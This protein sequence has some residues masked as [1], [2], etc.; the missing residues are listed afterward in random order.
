MK[1]ASRNRGFTLIDVLVLIVLIGTVAGSMT[2]LFSRL[3]AQ[4]AQ[5]MRARQQLGLA[6][7][8]LAE[9]RLMPM[10]AGDPMGPAGKSRY[11]GP[12]RFDNVNDYNGLML[13]DA[14]CAGGICDIGRRALIPAGSPLTGCS[15]TIATVPQALPGVPAVDALRI[16]V[17]VRCPGQ[18]DTT[19]EGIR[20]RHS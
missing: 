10:T 9:V 4:S 1:P 15:A 17:T 19:A 20:I 3:S 16:V 11:P 2:V 12:N 8:L 7:A 5:T 13:P 14:G 18:P 6:Q